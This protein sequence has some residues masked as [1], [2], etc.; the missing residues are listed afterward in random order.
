MVA[1]DRIQVSAKVARAF[2]GGQIRGS[3]RLETRGV[4]A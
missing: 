1:F 2:A 3:L 4:E